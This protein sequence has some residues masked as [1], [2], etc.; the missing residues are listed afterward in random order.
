[1]HLFSPT[2]CFNS[3][4]CSVLLRRCVVLKSC[5]FDSDSVCV[6]VGV[7]RVYVWKK[8]TKKTNPY[9]CSCCRSSL[10]TVVNKILLKAPRQ[11]C[12]SR[13]DASQLELVCL[14]M[15]GERNSTGRHTWSFRWLG[16][17]GS[18]CS[19][20]K[21]RADAANVTVANST[22][23]TSDTK[24][25][26]QLLSSFGFDSSEPLWISKTGDQTPY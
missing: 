24:V 7:L 11:V 6:T 25:F 2:G 14:P 8:N 18:V 20:Q 4:L 19:D 10:F 15:H 12:F 22:A 17:A 13:S 5:C 1:M 26:T 21:N 3:V 9:C 16:S 23:N